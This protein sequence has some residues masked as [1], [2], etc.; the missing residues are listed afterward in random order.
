[1]SRTA[2]AKPQAKTKPAPA[3]RAAPPPEPRASEPGLRFVYGRELDERAV[4]LL[5]AIERAPD[6]ARHREAF[7]ELV[8]ALTDA[9]L[10]HYFLRPLEVANAGFVVRQSANLGL[11]G[12]RNLLA[13][14]LRGALSRLEPEQLRTIAG[15]VRGMMVEA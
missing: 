2:A 3:R 9:G 13:P 10:T 4:A 1:M 11:A 6:P 5:D 12:A 15:Y 8:L 7:G 14:I